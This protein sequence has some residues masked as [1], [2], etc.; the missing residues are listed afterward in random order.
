MMFVILHLLHV[1]CISHNVIMVLTALSSHDI[2]H[3]RVVNLLRVNETGRLHCG[4][5]VHLSIVETVLFG[6]GGVIC[7]GYLKLFPYVSLRMFDH[8]LSW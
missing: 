3:W 7:A 5:L 6:V 4:W 1:S 2:S 8:T